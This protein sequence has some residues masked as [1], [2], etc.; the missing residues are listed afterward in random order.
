MIE[1]SGNSVDHGNMGQD[2][3]RMTKLDLKGVDSL[4]VVCHATYAFAPGQRGLDTYK[5]QGILEYTDTASADK[6]WRFYR[7]LN[8]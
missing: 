4:T 6:A 1:L 8:H 3:N 5:C 7:L 2:R